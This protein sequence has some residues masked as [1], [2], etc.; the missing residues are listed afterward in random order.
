MNEEQEKRHDI[1]IDNLR[2]ATREYYDLTDEYSDPVEYMPIEEAKD[3]AFRAVRKGQEFHVSNI[4][5]YPEKDGHTAIIRFT[6]K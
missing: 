6:D 1:L 2:K 5:I 4:V 3:Y